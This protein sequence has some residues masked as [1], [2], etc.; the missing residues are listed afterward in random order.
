[1]DTDDSVAIGSTAG[2]GSVADTSL[3]DSEKGEANISKDVDEARASKV[4]IIPPKP[5]LA[6]ATLPATDAD[7]QGVT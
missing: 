2:E 1:M 3:V 4:T 6:L 7:T 5:A